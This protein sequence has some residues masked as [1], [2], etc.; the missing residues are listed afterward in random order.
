MVSFLKETFVL[1]TAVFNN[2][3]Y[4]N[5]PYGV[6]NMAICFSCENRSDFQLMSYKHINDGHLP[7][8]YY[9]DLPSMKYKIKLI[10]QDG[11][12]G[13]TNWIHSNNST[14]IAADNAGPAIENLNSE[15]KN[16]FILLSFVLSSVCV[17]VLKIFVKCIKKR[18]KTIT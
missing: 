7:V 1:L 16:I 6:K 4:V 3:L 15:I 13:D 8:F 9:N 5:T 18:I 12:E 14:T 17:L 11:T 2:I 10:F